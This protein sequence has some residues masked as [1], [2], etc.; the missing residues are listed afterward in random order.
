MSRLV[1]VSEFFDVPD[2]MTQVMP[3]ADILSRLFGGE[4]KFGPLRL[5]ERNRVCDFLRI[6]CSTERQ[7]IKALDTRLGIFPVCHKTLGESFGLFVN[8]RVIHKDQ[9][10]GGHI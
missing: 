7:P 5:E 8:E 1:E 10:L 6:W 2:D 4:P 9:S 3:D